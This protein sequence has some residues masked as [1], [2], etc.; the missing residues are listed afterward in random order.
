MT[1]ITTPRI[2][3]VDGFCCASPC[4]WTRIV[5]GITGIA[6]TPFAAQ[7]AEISGT[8]KRWSTR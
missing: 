8:T 6:A 3:A 5:S 4:A 1:A 7:L 2:T